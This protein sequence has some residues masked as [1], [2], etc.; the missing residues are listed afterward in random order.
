MSDVQCIVVH[1]ALCCNACCPAAVY[2]HKPGLPP[3]EACRFTCG[4]PAFLV[5]QSSFL[6]GID[7][8]PTVT[9]QTA[10]ECAEACNA[11]KYCERCCWDVRHYTWRACMGCRSHAT[12]S[13]DAAR[14]A[15]LPNA[16]PPT[17][18]SLAMQASFG[19]CAP[20]QWAPP[21]VRCPASLPMPRHRRCQLAHVSCPMM[22]P[23]TRWPTSCCECLVPSVNEGVVHWRCRSGSLDSKAGEQVGWSQAAAAGQAHKQNQGSTRAT[24]ACAALSASAG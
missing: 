4:I 17:P 6:Q 5:L 19:A 16:H 2:A 8:L 1:A 24:P 13:A 23:R 20:R 15:Y 3:A 18:P 21:A 12:E 22:V 11:D 7:G 9:A 14:F 10:T